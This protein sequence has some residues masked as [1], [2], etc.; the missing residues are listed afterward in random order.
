M[1]QSP[2]W[3]IAS[4]EFKVHDHTDALHKTVEIRNREAVFAR[5]RVPYGTIVYTG[6]PLCSF[7][8]AEGADSMGITMSLMQLY[9]T[10]STPKKAGKA[11]AKLYHGCQTHYPR[12]DAQFKACYGAL[13]HKGVAQKLEILTA[14]LM[15]NKMQQYVEDEDSKVSRQCVYNQGSKFNHA[16]VPNCRWQIDKEGRLVIAAMRDIE[17][18][19]EVT[20]H[21]RIMQEMIGF[22]PKEPAELRTKIRRH[23]LKKYHMFECKCDH[24]TRKVV[25]SY[26][27]QQTFIVS[28]QQCHGPECKAILMDLERCEVCKVVAWCGAGCKA[29]NAETHARV[30]KLHMAKQ[31]FELRLDAKAEPKEEVK[32]AIPAKPLVVNTKYADYPVPEPG[33]KAPETTCLKD[34][35][36]VAFK[37]CVAFTP[38][39]CEELDGLW[40]HDARSWHL[41]TDPTNGLFRSPRGHKFKVARD[42]PCVAYVELDTKDDWEE[43]STACSDHALRN[44][45]KVWFNM[46]K[47]DELGD[48]FKMINPST[49]HTYRGQKGDEAVFEPCMSNGPAWFRVPV[50]EK[51]VVRV[52]L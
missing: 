1:A 46:A 35:A 9:R 33:R 27:E 29:A 30:C 16:C 31:S 28:L 14:R 43:K 13:P 47:V 24:C 5:A 42:E 23:I 20:I 21:Y 2:E 41:V 51:C 39:K 50:A 49:E 25:F 15:I 6:T 34:H 19:E 7:F 26:P 40:V 37:S 44:G 18:G 11:F 52:E 4:T 22:E 48:K 38:A 8:L 32:M 12:T 36:L 10:D 45:S 17:A 3:R